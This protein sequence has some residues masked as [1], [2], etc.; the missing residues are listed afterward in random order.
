MRVLGRQP[1]H[2]DHADAGCVIW[3]RNLG[4]KEKRKK[5][6]L[7]CM[8]NRNTLAVFSRGDVMSSEKLQRLHDVNTLVATLTACEV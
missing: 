1:P 3:K 5:R 2:R 6:A 4:E 8:W 7:I